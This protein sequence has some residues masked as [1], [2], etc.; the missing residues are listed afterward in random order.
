MLEVG[1]AIAELDQ[2]GH[3]ELVLHILLKGLHVNSLHFLGGPSFLVPVHIQQGGTHQLGGHKAHIE[4]CALVQLLHEA[5]GNHLTSLVVTGVVL[6]YLR[7]KCPVLVDLRGHLDK[8]AVGVGTC[9]ATILHAGEHAV[10]GMAE[11]VEDG[12]YLV[13]GEQRGG[14]A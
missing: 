14:V 8:I 12:L 9:Q 13:P 1:A 2:C 11:L 10:E 7:L 5:V 3:I 6:Q 4:L